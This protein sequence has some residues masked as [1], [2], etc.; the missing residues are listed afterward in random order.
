MWPTVV[1]EPCLSSVQL[2][3]VVHFASPGQGLVSVLLR[4]QSGAALVSSD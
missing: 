4:G 2:T 3:V 1:V